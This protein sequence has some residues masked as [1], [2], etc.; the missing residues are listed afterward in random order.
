MGLH[1]PG[2][3]GGATRAAEAARD[4]ARADD[5]AEAA[6]VLRRRDGT[7]PLIREA[8]VVDE[9]RRAGAVEE[10]EVEAPLRG[11]VRGQRPAAAS[12]GRP[13]AANSAAPA[14]ATAVGAPGY[15]EGPAARLAPSLAIA[16]AMVAVTTLPPP[17]LLPL[18]MLLLLLLL[19]SP[20]GAAAEWSTV[21]SGASWTPARDDFWM[22][23]PIDI[24]RI[25]NTVPNSV[26]SAC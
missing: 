4:E 5:D 16:A 1:A 21:A 6:L 2:T 22:H 24:I 3:C 8:E 18:L 26:R 20:F 17:L 14:R 12:G 11:G 25:G 7:R 19:K 10:R 9:G 15:P 23:M 13:A